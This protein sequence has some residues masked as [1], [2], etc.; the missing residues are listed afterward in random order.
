MTSAIETPKRRFLLAVLAG[1]P[2]IGTLLFLPASGHA[3]KGG[4]PKNDCAV[5]YLITSIADDDCTGP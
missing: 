1:A 3:H 5:E 4:P 2:L